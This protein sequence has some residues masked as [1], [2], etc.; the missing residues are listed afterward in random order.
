M[1]LGWK[2]DYIVEE[3]VLYVKL[4]CVRITSFILVSVFNMFLHFFSF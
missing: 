4:H 1:F 3:K 2:R